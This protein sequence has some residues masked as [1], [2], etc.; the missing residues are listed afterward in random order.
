MFGKYLDLYSRE[1]VRIIYIYLFTKR[2]NPN[3]SNHY[4]TITPEEFKQT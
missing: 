3:V 4:G 2:S 1:N